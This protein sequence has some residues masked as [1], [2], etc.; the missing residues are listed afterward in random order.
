[1]RGTAR[2]LLAAV[3]TSTVL[4][5][6]VLTGGVL[7]PVLLTGGVAAAAADG[8]PSGTGMPHPTGNCRSELPRAKA[9]LT[10][11][12]WAQRALQF[13]DVWDLT[14]GKGVTVAVV[15]SGVDYTSQLAGRVSWIDEVG[16]DPTDCEGHGTA[17]ASIIAASNQRADNVP[18]YGAAP[19]ARILSVKVTQGSENQ[20]GSVPLARGIV[21]AVNAGA[22]VINLSIETSQSTAV[23]TAAVRYAEQHNVVLVAAAGNDSSSTGKGPFFPASYPGVI[24]VGAVEEGGE[25][26][27]YTDK[28][29]PVSVVAPG[30][31]IASDSPGGYVSDDDGTSFAAAFVSGEAALIRSLDSGMP[32]AQVAATI[33]DTADGNTGTHTGAG[34]INP[35]AAITGLASAA[36]PG[37]TTSGGPVSIP[38]VQHT[39]KLTRTVAVSVTAGAAGAVVLVIACALIIPR[40]RRRG[41]RPGRVDLTTVGGAPTDL[42]A[43]WAD[44]PE[45]PP[46]RDTRASPGRETRITGED[47]PRPLPTGRN[48]LRRPSGRTQKS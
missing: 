27:S 44:D 9:K 24:S 13:S 10:S 46:S 47:G 8:A 11:E 42:A 48:S 3:L 4:T 7:A 5:S 40:G 32:A 33:K 43:H 38:R 17:V 31:G 29:T 15:D 21:A 19:A 23:L 20:N 6:T 45:Q 22:K 41:W 14:Q 25:L 28:K 39:P 26:A 16:S 2:A 34:M 37:P 18:F 1:M 36:S 12:P 30:V 35:V